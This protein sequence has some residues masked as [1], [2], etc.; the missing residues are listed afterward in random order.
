VSNLQK[1]GRSNLTRG[2]RVERASKLIMATG[3]GGVLL[4]VTFVLALL[5]AVSAA[6]PLVVAVVTGAL[7]YGAYRTVKR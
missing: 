1:R 7:A 5:G 2:Q 3:V 6:V 4:G